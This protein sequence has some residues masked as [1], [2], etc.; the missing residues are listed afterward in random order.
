MN[1]L[2]TQDVLLELNEEQLRILQ[3]TLLEMFCDIFAVCKKYKIPIAFAGGSAL[4]AIRHQGFI[5][6]DDDLDLLMTRAAYN[7]FKSVFEAELSDKYI[8]NAP[9]YKDAAK[10]RFAKILK[11]GTAYEEILD[12]KEK[13]N[14]KICLDL[15]ML[16]L[17]FF[18]TKVL[19]TGKTA[20]RHSG[21]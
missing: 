6:W 1:N 4:G 8:L 10:A 19:R 13:E 3:K 21:K 9:N 12:S 15:F 2:A 17:L 20:L 5:T 7:R 11:K 16:I 14:C 18:R